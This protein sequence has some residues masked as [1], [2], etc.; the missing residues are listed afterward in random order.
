[1]ARHT[2]YTTD[3]ARA[4]TRQGEANTLVMETKRMMRK[5]QGFIGV[6]AVAAVLVFRAGMAQA[7][8]PFPGGLPQ[9]QAQLS[10]CQAGVQAFPATGQTTCWNSAG[11]V[12]SCAG[13]GQDGDIQA[14]ATLSYTDN[15]DG[16]ITDNNTKL[17][18]E[19]QSVAEGSIH[20]MDNV[21]TWADAFAVHVAGLNAA[22]F[23]GH[24][25]WRLPNVKEL[26]SIVDYQN[27]SPAV[28]SA[29]HNAS[30]IGG[31]SVLTASCTRGSP[32]GRLRPPP[33]PQLRSHVRP[34]RELPQRLRVCPKQE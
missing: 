24:N 32:T 6:A 17:V 1:V 14:G 16:T 4:R 15:G 27:R 20:D 9:C 12:I 19:K 8:P 21:Y 3:L 11:A 28:A 29:F 31:A 7:Q 25:D 34:F 10:A 5:R 2:F 33:T 23:A 26:L 30:C 22:N 13:T 18:W